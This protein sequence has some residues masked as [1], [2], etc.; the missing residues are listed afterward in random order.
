MTI[1]ELW[2]SI[3][4]LILN[5]SLAITLHP[6]VHPQPSLWRMRTKV[7]MWLTP[8]VKSY[9]NS[10]VNLA[11]VL[12]DRCFQLFYITSQLRNRLKL[13][14]VRSR[15]ISIQKFANNCPENILE[16]V[17]LRILALDGSEICVNCFVKEI[18]A[19]LNSKKKETFLTLEISFLRTVILIMKTYQLI[20]LSGWTILLVSYK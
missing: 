18:C 17:N 7:D 16:K 13:K 19:T 12:F 11:R 6:P 3:T 9:E 2:N 15:K 10:Y 5:T 14:T 4:F 20:F 1:H 8:K